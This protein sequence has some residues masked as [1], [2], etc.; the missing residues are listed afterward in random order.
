MLLYD[1]QAA[2]N[3]KKKRERQ[4]EA[5]LF[6]PLRARRHE[7]DGSDCMQDRKQ[8]MYLISKYLNNVHQGSSLCVSLKVKKNWNNK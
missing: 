1:R 5:R 8:A 4:T 3:K 7:D 2:Q 6:D